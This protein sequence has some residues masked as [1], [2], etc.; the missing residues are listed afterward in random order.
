MK[1]RLLQILI[2]IGVTLTAWVTLFFI[3]NVVLGVREAETKVNAYEEAYY[4]KP[5]TIEMKYDWYS[6]GGYIG[7]NYRY[8]PEKNIIFDVKNND[9]YRE[10]LVERIEVIED[11]MGTNIKIEDYSVATYYDGSDVMTRYDDLCIYELYNAQIV[12][13]EERVQKAVDIIWD[14]VVRLRANYYN[15]CGIHVDY[16]DLGG[17]YHFSINLEKETITKEM[18][19]NC[20][21]EVSFDENLLI[22][23]KWTNFNEH[24]TTFWRFEVDD[25]EISLVAMDDYGDYQLVLKRDE[26]EKVLKTYPRNSYKPEELKTGTFDNILGFSGFY[27][28]HKS[29]PY[30]YGY[31]YTI[32]Q[33][34]L[35]C[36][37]TGCGSHEENSFIVDVNNDG[38]T[39]LICN[40]TFGA[41]GG[42]HTYIY[43]NNGTQILEG[44]CDDLLD[45]EYDNISYGSSGS[46]YVPENEVVH[47][48]YWLES[49]QGFATKDYK[50]DLEK[51]VFLPFAEDI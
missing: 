40:V 2:S 48:F 49:I 12:P 15:I 42:K 27:I 37:G 22:Y 51:I 44:V 9:L 24:R 36:I 41:D 8:N 20:A 11:Y 1:K 38:I 6:G 35:V 3:D 4:M 23:E 45:V 18:L 10:H 7:E 47:I 43:Y 29:N 17:V 25:Y 46:W 32:I 31:Y 26:T 16:Y 28:F 30:D 39:E 34:E 14:I 33:D 21:K 50:I 13:E 19:L 5:E